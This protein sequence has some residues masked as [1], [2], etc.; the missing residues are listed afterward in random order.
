MMLAEFECPVHGRF[1][2]L[3]DRVDGGPP[4][5][6]PC[7]EWC[8]SASP[9]TANEPKF[10]MREEWPTLTR[11]EPVACGLASPWRISSPHPKVLSVPC[12]AAVRGGDMKDRPPGMLDTRKLA[13][14]QSMKEWK[15]ERE[16][17]RLERRHQ[18]LLKN[19]MV[20]KK[21][22]VGAG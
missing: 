11:A 18:Q 6:A 1:E 15:G 4:D 20:Q 7:P 13:D 17:E 12:F 3:V 10:G 8:E 14:G 2:A 9:Q 22:I 21:I 19:G 16:K 5:S